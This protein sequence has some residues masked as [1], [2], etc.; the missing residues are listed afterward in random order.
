MRSTTLIR[1]EGMESL[2]KTLGVLETEIFISSLLRDS[3]DYTE[4]QREYFSNVTLNDFL[5][6]ALAFDKKNPFN[7]EI[8]RQVVE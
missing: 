2:I 1:K 8:N 4:W 3:F 7:S 5:S 6:N